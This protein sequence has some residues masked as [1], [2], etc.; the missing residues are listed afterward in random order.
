[1]APT[2]AIVESI[3][4]KEYTEK[5]IPLIEA[6]KWR[7]SVLVFDWRWY[8]QDISSPASLLNQAILR[9]HR[10]KL[11]VRAL[12]NMADTVRELTGLGMKVRKVWSKDLLH[13]KVM[14]IDDEI[15]VIGSHNFT[16]SAFS[17]NYECSVIIKG[18]EAVAPFVHYFETIYEYD[19]KNQS[20]R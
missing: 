12:V 7:V 15:A 8:P 6:A 9:A 10:R 20:S 4:G 5:V 13:A 17:K 3:L 1:M 19:G 2:N 18:K 11:D 14:L 16:A